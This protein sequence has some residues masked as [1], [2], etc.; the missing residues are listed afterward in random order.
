MYNR[1]LDSFL[2]I[3]ESGSFSAAA[4]RLFVSRPALIQ[5]INL[6]EKELG[7][8]LFYRHNRG[9]TLTPAGKYFYQESRKAI[10]ASNKILRRC[11]SLEEKSRETVRIGTLP[12]FTAVL[13]PQICRRFTELYPQINLQFIEYPLENYFKNFITSSFDITTEYMSGYAFDEPDYKF[14]KLME[15]KHCCGMSPRHPLAGKKRISLEDLKDQK[16]LIYARGIT[17]AD[18]ALRSFIETNAPSVELI[19]IYHYSSSLPLRCELEGLILIYYSMYWES[20]PTLVTVP[21]DM[22]MAFPINIG[23]GYRADAGQAVKLFI[24][25]AQELYV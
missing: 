17:R 13:L 9:V 5:Q 24:E 8:Q 14:V 21:I 11:R 10:D 22:S 6:L 18:D 25:L 15:D 12:N 16:V 23:L 3:A 2:A 19:D 1:H 7:F 20:F 4:D